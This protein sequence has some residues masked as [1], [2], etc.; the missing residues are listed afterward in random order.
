VSARRERLFAE[1]AAELEALLRRSPD[2]P[3][4]ALYLGL[5]LADQGHERAV[6]L[7]QSALIGFGRTGDVA[8]AVFA[9]LNLA[10]F[11]MRRGQLQEADD[12]ASAAV[13]AARAA[14]FRV[15]AGRALI[16]KGW[17]AYRQGDYGRAWR[18][19]KESERDVFPDAPPFV[20][21]AWL[22]AMGA[23][24]WATGP[25]EESLRYYQRQAELL[26]RSGD[27]YDE[28]VA[29][30]NIVLLANI[31]GVGP[32]E[33]ATLAHEALRSAI[34]GGNRG[35]EARAHAHLAS[36]TEGG[37][38]LQHA[39][40]ALAIAEDINDVAA[41]AIGRRALADATAESDP[42]AAIR[43]IDEAIEDAWQLG[44]RNELARNWITKSRIRWQ[45]GP[46]D[47]AIA[48]SLS[49]IEHV[50]ATRDLQ[51]DALVRARRFSQFGEAYTTLVGRLLGGERAPGG[52]RTPLPE[53]VELAFAVMERRRA[54]MLIDELDAAHASDVVAPA[55][56]LRDERTATLERIV[57]TQRTLMNPALDDHR[58]RTTLAEL[59]RLE[60][61][62]ML[63]RDD[64]ARTSSRFGGL[65][66][67]TIATVDEVR[68]RLSDDE[69]LL[70]F[71]SYLTKSDAEPVSRA[72][73]SGERSTG[74]LRTFM[75]GS[76]LM[77]ST[78]GAT[79]VYRMP[80][81]DEIDPAVSL[82]LGLLDRRDGSEARGAA[83]LY[84]DLLQSALDD[85]PSSV[86]R[87]I[88]VPDR[89]LHRLPFAALRPAPGQPSVAERYEI[90]VVPSATVWLRWRQAPAERMPQAVLAMADPAL[91]TT[92]DHV[93][94]M[95][96]WALATSF[97]PG[98][99]PRARDE[100][101]S[102]T[103][104]LGGGSRVVE[105]DRAT[106][107]FL[108]HANLDRFAV[109]HFAAHAV[110][111]DEHPE[112]SAVVLA[113]G[114]AAEDGLLQPRE[115]VGL[116]LDRRI[117]VLSAC[118]SGVGELLPGEGMMSLA[119]AFFQ[120]GADAVVASL[121]PLR[122]EDAAEFFEPFYQYLARGLNVSAALAAA[123]RDRIRAG[124]P[125]AA[126]AGIVLLGNGDP[127][128]VPDGRPRFVFP[129]WYGAV[130]TLL[131]ILA[132]LFLR[133][134]RS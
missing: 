60:R 34:A 39:R 117:V 53:D 90:S 18:L 92:G 66:R 103:R 24:R 107:H 99:L 30:G 22:S 46:R 14:N 31:V 20:Q 121:W 85:L 47:S 128:P 84:R 73:Q 113:P 59:E 40:R 96:A 126:W 87:L 124:A 19:L 23:V 81:A 89:N 116:D 72:T 7:F 55:G 134:R 33:L 15:L 132:L 78:R 108:K 38:R 9:R 1:A 83:R 57:E 105:G 3:L 70:A 109:L 12:H 45:A 86:R 74:G 44:D 120:A 77:V 27:R 123:T 56:S 58:R 26:R 75:G 61:A 118:Q 101:Q 82:F 133:N 102:A 4:P 115:I 37:V 71:Q 25:Q 8:G 93:A 62:E 11:L 16:T 127:T 64:L 67:P 69:A 91:P 6:S 130:G 119:H 122:D 21:S 114:S 111:D 50:E 36:V 49:A 51:P 110:V 29:R 17:L 95:R 63:L 42:P 68:T 112:R 5:V 106:E 10:D 48:D 79:R 41:I 131:A 125:A 32:D 28:A 97:E 35:S 52:A 2:N 80:D 54:R 43:I 88:I 13:A 94:S 76:W 65:R 129:S 98:R 100:A 104:A